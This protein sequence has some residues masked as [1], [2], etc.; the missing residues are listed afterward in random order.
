MKC[1]RKG[2]HKEH[3]MYRI[4][5]PR[6]RPGYSYFPFFMPPTPHPHH[7][8]FGPW[9]RGQ[10]RGCRGGPRGRR[11]RCGGPRNRCGKPE[12]KKQQ[13]AT[14]EATDVPVGPPLLHA[15]GEAIANFLG[16]MG[17][18]VHTYADT[19]KGEISLDI[20]KIATKINCC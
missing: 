19:E 15:M 9:G 11:D 14:T 6:N 16:P 18:E 1:E 17:I 8:G 12:G 20:K 13:E 7:Q 2:Q 10:G 5:T 3:E 4:C